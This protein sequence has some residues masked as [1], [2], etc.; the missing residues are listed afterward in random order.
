M[1]RPSIHTKPVDFVI[2]N[3]AFRKCQLEWI[4]LKTPAKCSRVD[5]DLFEN[6]AFQKR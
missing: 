5:G 4:N 1:A 6:G 2:E 3:G